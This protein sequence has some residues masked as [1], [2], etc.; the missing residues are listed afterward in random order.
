M[1]LKL[2]L[3]LIR[4]FIIGLEAQGIAKEPCYDNINQFPC[5]VPSGPSGT[6]VNDIGFQDIEVIFALGDTHLAG[7]GIKSRSKPSESFSRKYPEAGFAMGGE[8]GVVTLANIMKKYNGG[9]LGE[10]TASDRKHNFAAD[11]ATTADLMSQVQALITAADDFRPAFKLV[12]ILIGQNDFCKKACEKNYKVADSVENI[13][14]V[15]K[16][17]QAKIS[18]VFVNIMPH[19]NVVNSLHFYKKYESQN[20]ICKVTLETECPCLFNDT[21]KIDEKKMNGMQNEYYQDLV[22][23]INNGKFDSDK[24]AVVINDVGVVMNASMSNK[25][26]AR[27]CIHYDQSTQEMFAVSAFN[28]LFREVHKKEIV[29]TMPSKLFCPET[30]DGAKKIPILKTK[31]NSISGKKAL[32]YESS[33]TYDPSKVT[34]LIPS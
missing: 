26:M 34:C 23:A 15:L 6:T 19:F 32:K 24:M 31:T 16:E 5:Q 28:Q 4:S 21:V 11:D 17:I 33:P 10:S 30:T 14:K 2:T 7:A 1:K 8:P 29:N 22:T 12:H 13:I 25:F 9:L 20:P 3:L 27:D 18:K